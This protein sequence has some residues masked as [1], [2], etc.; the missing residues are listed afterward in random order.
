MFLVF[1]MDGQIFVF[2]YLPFGLAVAPWAFT[3]IIRPIKCYLQ[4]MCFRVS[5]FLDDFLLLGETPKELN[6]V[7]AF[8]LGLFRRLGFTINEEVVYNSCAENRISRG[9]FPF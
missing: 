8:V 9:S 1:V 3:R 4:Q 2:Q 5:S 6:R 7:S